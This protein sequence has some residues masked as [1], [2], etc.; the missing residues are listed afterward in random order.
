MMSVC[1]LFCF[2]I[3]YL[4]IDSKMESNVLERDESNRQAIASNYASIMENVNSISRMIMADEEVRAYLSSSYATYS[5]N[6]ATFQA[7]H[8]I[9]NTSNLSCS[10]TV[11]RNDKLYLTTGPGILKVHSEI[12]FDTDWLDKVREK[13]GG[14]II[15]TDKKKAFTSNI[16]KM[17]TF[18]RI[19]N[20]ENTQKEIG[21]LVINVPIKFFQNALN[22]VSDADNHFALYDKN[23]FLLCCDSNNSFPE[24]LTG[25]V[26][27][28]T[29]EKKGVFSESVLTKSYF[30]EGNFILVSRSVVKLVEGVSMQLVL[31][32]VICI[33]MILFFL[34]ILNKFLKKQIINPIDKLVDSMGEIENG[35]LHR[36]SIDVGDDEIGRLKNSYNAMLIEINQLI[37][38]LVDK[39]KTLKQA[40]LSAL[41]EQIKPHFLYNTLDMIRLLALEGQSEKV[42]DLLET[43]SNFYRRFLSKGSTDITLGEEIE[44]V[45]NYLKLQKYRFEEV[46]DAIYEIDEDVEKVYVPRLILQPLVENSI[47]HGIRPK[48]EKCEIKIKAYHDDKFVYVSVYD[49]GIGIDDEKKAKLSKGNDKKSFGFKGTMNR[50][51]YYYKT[52]DVFEIRSVLGEYCEILLKLPMQENEGGNRYVQSDD[53]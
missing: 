32:I 30:G 40:E 21:V 16:S 33:L 13:K 23:K 52:E 22:S 4:F 50:I 27:G 19:I 15:V 12:I 37:N 28:G 14:Q 42:Y 7:I 36:V 20:D 46:F 10:V 44:I 2:V 25:D 26:S 38:E 34:L 39:E 17:V 35:W 31:V 8:N 3:F 24:E 41:Q 43:L 47:Y 48:G 11:I 5:E 45:Q 51:K 18:A 6:R 29:V 9:L 53:N 49:S 1:L